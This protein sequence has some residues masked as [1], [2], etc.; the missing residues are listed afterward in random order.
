MNINVK[1]AMKNSRSLFSI[2]PTY[3]SAPNATPKK[4]NGCSL[5]SGI[6]QVVNSH[7]L[8]E[9]TPDVILVPH[10]IAHPVIEI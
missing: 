1:L 7:P 6:H 10:L 4:S 3:L 8:R 9:E 2:H 5:F